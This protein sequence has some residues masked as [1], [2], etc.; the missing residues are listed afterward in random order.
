MEKMSESIVCRV[1]CQFQF[2]RVK[3]KDVTPLPSLKYHN[4][5][6]NRQLT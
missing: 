4:K 5:V 2:R 6:P 1:H 3:D